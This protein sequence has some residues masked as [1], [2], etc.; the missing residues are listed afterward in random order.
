MRISDWSSDVCSSDLG[1][2]AAGYADC[3]VAGAHAFALA[4][5][6]R[7]VGGA[8]PG[9]AAIGARLLRVVGD[10]A[11]RPV[12]PCNGISGNR[13][14]GVNL[15]GAGDRIGAVFAAVHGAAAAVRV[16]VDRRTAAGTGGDSA[17]PSARSVLLRGVS[18]DQRGLSQRHPPDVSA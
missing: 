7:R 12:G 2:V 8:A 9:V 3:V 5:R 4:R 18:A 10:G 11:E 13:A 14:A 1:T 16:L 17:R 6:D 15:P